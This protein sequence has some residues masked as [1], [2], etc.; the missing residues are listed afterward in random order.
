MDALRNTVRVSWCSDWGRRL[1]L[2]QEKSRQN[3]AVRSYTRQ[4]TIS[5]RRSAAELIYRDS[6]FKSYGLEGFEI[7][8]TE[9]LLVENQYGVENEVSGDQIS[10]GKIQKTLARKVDRRSYIQLGCAFYRH[11]DHWF[12]TV[13]VSDNVVGSECKQVYVQLLECTAPT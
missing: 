2:G 10:L 7:I 12:I 8:R 5:S 13:V 1:K 11:D 4:L 3:D 9:I 6:R